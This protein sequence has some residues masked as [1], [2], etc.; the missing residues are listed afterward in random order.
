MLTDVAFVAVAF[1]VLSYA[2][3][4]T[5]TVTAA[6]PVVADKLPPIPTNSSGLVIDRSNSG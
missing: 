1:A 3:T 4:L 6:V 2:G 5:V